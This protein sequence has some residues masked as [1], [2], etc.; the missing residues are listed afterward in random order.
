[1]MARIVRA[2]DTLLL[3]PK[4]VLV[5]L[6]S[7]L[8]FFGYHTK[9]FRLDASADTLLLEDDRDLKVYRGIQE[10]YPSNDLLIVTFTPNENLFSDQALEPLKKLRE[11]LEKV[12]IVDSVFS[13]LDAPLFNSSDTDIQEMVNNMPSLEKPGI[14]RI[15][16]RKE[17]INSP[18]YRDLI[19][20]SDGKSAALLL[21]LVENKKFN[22]LLKSR[23]DL[24]TKRRQ[25]GLS[26]K[27]TRSLQRITADYDRV[28]ETRSLKRSRDIARIRNII[29]PYR[30]YGDLHLGGLPMITDDMVTFVRNDLIVFGGGVLAFLVVILT[31]IFRKIRWISLPLI[32]C[33]YSASVMIGILGLIGWKVTV[34][35]SNFLALMLIITISMNIHLIVRYLQLHRD[36]PDDNQFSLVRTTIHK[37]VKPCL[38]TSLTTIIG[39]GS[40]VVSDIKPVI[41]FGWMMSAGLAVTFATAFLLFPTLLLVIGKSSDKTTAENDQFPIPSYLARITETHGGKILLFAAVLTALSIA[42]IS[43]LRVENSFIN[44]FSKDT[45]IYQGLKLIDEK[46]GGTTPLE[47]IIKLEQ[48][49]EELTPEDLKE[50]TK[51]EIKEEREFLAQLRSKPE[52]WFNP[53]KVELIKKAH[54]YLDG[55][56]EIG[57]VLSFASSVRVAEAFAEKKLDGMELSILYTKLPPSVKKTIVEPFVSIKNN[58][59]RLSARVLDSTPE[60][61]RKELLEKVRENLLKKDGLKQLSDFTPMIKDVTVSG[62]LVLYNNMLQSLF[63]SQIKTIGVVMFGIAI[64]FLILFRSVTLSIIGILPNLLGAAVVLGLMGWSK[65]PMDMMTI[66]IAAITIGIAVDNGIH[67]IYRFKE[68]YALSNDYIETL[69]ICHSNIGK[70]VFYTTMTVIFGFSILMLSNFIPTIIFGVLTGAAM[71]IALLAALT[72]LPKMIL[73][74]KPF[75]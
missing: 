32:S 30:Q 26:P 71:L 50:M 6:L 25:T 9:D 12:A 1:M 49:G 27:E 42:G 39:F 69:H 18:I 38:Y 28:G 72:V 68:E 56:P 13:I 54:D 67:Y 46:L 62:L 36:H 24:R 47:V 75:G 22:L 19:V 64:M 57:K 7:I 70:A 66:T 20:S 23:D 63:A 4:L 55:L 8:V 60:L 16:A 17:L 52:L 59:V 58:E 51:E 45:E 65:I 35:S 3:N 15:R 44:Y 34:I 31:A 40:L 14:D 21:S 61:R 10:R 33:F 53:T 11:E 37:M 74:W 2:Y 41:D 5:M 48:D 73:L 43:L 29:A